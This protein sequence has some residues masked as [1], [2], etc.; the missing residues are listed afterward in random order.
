VGPILLFVLLLVDAARRSSET[1][2]SI[3]EIIA[4]HIQNAVTGIKSSRFVRSK[5]DSKLLRRYTA[6]AKAAGRTG[7]FLS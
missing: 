3:I 2:R 5:D 1:G 4:E 7:T 6:T